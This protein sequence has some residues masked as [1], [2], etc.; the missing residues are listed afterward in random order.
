MGGGDASPNF[1]IQNQQALKEQSTFA[2]NLM[3]KMCQDR[4]KDLEISQYR[5]AKESGVPRST[6]SEWFSGKRSLNLRNFIA[7]LIVLKMNPQFVA[8]EDDDIDYPNRVHFN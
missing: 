6:L 5:L 4:M 3:I 7:V 1:L 8:K 2:E